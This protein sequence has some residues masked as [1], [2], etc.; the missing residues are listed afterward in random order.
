M[1][2][3]VH[4]VYIEN[5][6]LS[7]RCLRSSLYFRGVSFSVEAIN[8]ERQ[9]QPTHLTVHTLPLLGVFSPLVSISNWGITQQSLIY[10]YWLVF[11]IT[12]KLPTDLSSV[13]FVCLENL[14]INVM[15]F[16]SLPICWYSSVRE[17][18][19][20]R[21]TRKW[22]KARRGGYG[23]PKKRRQPTRTYFWPH[24]TI[25]PFVQEIKQGLN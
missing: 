25:Y 1:F 5:S 4:D 6:V 16:R 24:H 11:R 19:T 21:V 9:R 22:Y 7:F 13:G 14:H 12:L 15:L 10:V 8:S 23:V 17:L 18:S 20:F 3:Y 2:L